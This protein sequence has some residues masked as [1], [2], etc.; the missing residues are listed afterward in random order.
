MHDAA[1]TLA[2][3]TGIGVLLG[4]ERER[5]KGQGPGR[6]AAGVRTF[7]LVGLLGGLSFR[8]GGA[9]T[10]AVALAFVGVAAIAGYLHSHEQDPGL[11]TE[12]ALVVDFLL[13]ALA[14]REL[15]LASALAVVTALV[16]AHRH[17]LH[18]LVRDTLS[19]QELHDAL[20]FA[21]CAAIVLPLMP[22]RAIGP[23]G[24][25]NPATVWRLVVIVMAM[26]GAGY[27]ALRAIGP[28]YGLL[29]VGLISGFVSST[30][31]IGMMGARAVREPRIR[32]G[33]SAAAVVSSVA[34]IILLAVVVGAASLP[35]L[36]RL[37][38]PLLLAGVAAAAYAALFAVRTIRSPMPVD[39]ERGRAFDLRVALGL[40]VLVS[41]VLVVSGIL[42]AAAGRA[43]LI[44][45]TASAG[46]ADSQ[47]AAISAATLTRA[48]HA[49]ESAAVIAILAA[50]SANTLSKAIIAITL[51][52]RRFA[53]DVWPGLV[54]MLAGAWGG[55][56]VAGVL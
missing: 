20:L 46:F 33:A 27:V 8:V 7:A 50:L 36:R 45:G 2:V 34:T 25:L 22:D 38:L 16:L 52:D 24:S 40:A 30:A 53:F 32:R 21:A 3:A 15:T 12:V 55:A 13:G 48:G 17:R 47:S 28:R 26:Q 49:T 54:L 4:I 1:L 9:L 35:T 10:A 31:T 5:R 23:H 14:Q 19:E 41:V 42:T 51:G 29:V 44:I 43:G 37:A 11:T 39:V 18:A 56:A 6:G